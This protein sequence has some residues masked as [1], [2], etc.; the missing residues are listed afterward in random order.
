MALDVWAITTVYLETWYS[1]E[2]LPWG[3][4][5]RLDCK[6]A[7]FRNKCKFANCA[8][9]FK[10]TLEYISATNP[11]CN[12]FILL[13]FHTIWGFICLCPCVACDILFLA[14]GGVGTLVYNTLRTYLQLLINNW[15]LSPDALAYLLNAYVLAAP[16]TTVGCGDSQAHTFKRK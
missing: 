13:R 8:D 6:S 14:Q 2:K 11:T 12:N 1:G 15:G 5:R 10:P 7:E 9:K 3:R 4:L 16:I